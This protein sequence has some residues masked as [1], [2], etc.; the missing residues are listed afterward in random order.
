[1]RAPAVLALVLTTALAGCVG[2]PT[3]PLAPPSLPAAPFPSLAGAEPF[4]MLLCAGD[5]LKPLA[6]E[7]ADCN[8]QAT[9]DSGPAFEV[10]LAADPKDPLHLVAGAKDFSVGDEPGCWKRNVWTGVFV[11]RDGG[12]GWAHSLIPGWPGDDAHESLPLAQYPCASD[13][14][15][16]FAAD[17]TLYYA[18]LA[19]KPCPTEDQ[20]VTP[21]LE[22]VNACSE[23]SAMIVSRSQD[24]GA[25][26]DVQATAAER[27]GSAIL[28]KQWLAVDPATGQVYLSYIDTGTGAIEVQRSDDR[29]LSWL[30]PVPVVQPHPQPEGPDADQ[31]AEVAVGP[32][33]VVHVLYWATMTGQQ[34]S[35]LYHRAS[36][37]AGRTWDGP[38]LV[39][40]AVLLF[41]LGV[42]HKYRMVGL[43]ALAVDALDG[44][45]YA[46]WPGPD[47]LDSDIF[48][49]ASH[50]EGRSWAGDW[51]VND[52]TLV[53]DQGLPTN[54]QWMPA[55]AV[56]PD[57]TVHV[58]WLDYRDDP[59]G[60]AGRFLYAFSTT[61][62]AS[63]SKNEV[64]SDAS[65]DGTGGE[66]QSGSGTIGDYTGLVATPYAVHAIWADTRHARN[67]LFSATLLGGP[68]A[69]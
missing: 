31:F 37:D 20:P 40:R 29:G 43:P 53:S 25:T 19:Y 36:R 35:A 69:A 2:S 57:H 5:V 42:L 10:N 4:T 68:R 8:L 9:K 18:S 15:L 13:P 23:R 39:S 58:T 66:H 45:V 48:V 6:S 33:S 34:A 64:L 62:G 49:A 28:D 59:T 54:F 50:D 44:S 52:D 14:A 67:D 3:Q 41:D 46:A 16:A 63:W 65:F 27:F 12:R 30:A 60:Q 11:T 61:R 24:G 38:D 22:P 51:Q 1:M 55:V 32:G 7:H 56:G 21:L 47:P 26:W 17:G